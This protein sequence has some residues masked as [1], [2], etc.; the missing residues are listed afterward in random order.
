[1]SSRP[2]RVWR[3][4]DQAPGNAAAGIPASGARRRRSGRFTLPFTFNLQPSWSLAIRGPRPSWPWL[5]V[6]S[7]CSQPGRQV[8][9]GASVGQRAG[10]RLPAPCGS[11]SPGAASPAVTAEAGV[12]RQ[13]RA[14]KASG[15]LDSK[16]QTVNSIPRLPEQRKS[17][18]RSVRLQG[19][20]GDGESL[21]RYGRA[22]RWRMG[23]FL[24]LTCLRGAQQLSENLR[25]LFRI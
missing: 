10:S 12:L 14:C 13:S 3:C 16:P 15:G 22:V 23:P 9:G 6:L 8:G 24:R 11:S 4:D 2:L 19:V 1:M 7:V 25:H 18:G 5:G 17:Q 20:G 21:E